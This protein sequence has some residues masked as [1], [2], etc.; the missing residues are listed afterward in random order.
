MV[1]VWILDGLNNHNVMKSIPVMPM[2]NLNLVTV[3]RV[4]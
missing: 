1:K 4:D 2:L 3:Q